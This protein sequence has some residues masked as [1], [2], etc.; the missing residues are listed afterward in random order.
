M[1]SCWAEFFLD[2][3]LTANNLSVRIS[4]EVKQYLTKEPLGIY[5]ND[6]AYDRIALFLISLQRDRLI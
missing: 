5:L 1:A 3:F 2:V 4:I 6:P